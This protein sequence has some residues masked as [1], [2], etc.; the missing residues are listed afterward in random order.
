MHLELG[1]CMTEYEVMALRFEGTA[2]VLSILS[3]FSAF[4]SA[5]SAALYYFLHSTPLM[6]RI[7]I[8]GLLSVALV[9]LGMVTFGNWFLMEGLAVACAFDPNPQSEIMSFGIVLEKM[10]G[11]TTY[12]IAVL[13]G[14]CVAACVYLA[15]FVLTFFYRW[16][17]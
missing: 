10:T 17:E 14:C 9:F 2:L 1:R 8:F 15:L 16:A 7:L 5:Y 12:T 11:L 3:V 6:M 13:F 4:V